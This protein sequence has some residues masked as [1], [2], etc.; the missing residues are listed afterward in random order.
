MS[1][2]AELLRRL[3]MNDTL[4][5]SAPIATSTSSRQRWAGR[6]VSGLATLFMTFDGVFKLINPQPVIDGCVRMGLPPHLAPGI[7][8]LALALVALYLVPRTAV[9]GAALLTGY[10]GGAVALHV[11]LEDPLFTHT[12][13]PVYLGALFWIGLALRD[14]RVRALLSP[15]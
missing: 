14:A 5:L 4:S 2:L 10:L 6:I 12:L 3:D 15:A 8:V 11:R 13:F 7:G 1:I 9:L